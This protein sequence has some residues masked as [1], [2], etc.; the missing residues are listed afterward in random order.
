[1]P[2]YSGRLSF[3]NTQGDVPFLDS[4]RE[5]AK[6][7]QLP[8]EVFDP[9]VRLPW[10]QGQEWTTCHSG[11]L[12]VRLL[13]VATQ[14]MGRPAE[15]PDMATTLVTSAIEAPWIQILQSGW[16]VFKLLALLSRWASPFLDGFGAD[17]T[18]HGRSAQRRAITLHSQCDAGE[19]GA[20]KQ[21]RELI[22]SLWRHLDA[23][24]W[25]GNATVQ[26]ALAE[27]A[28]AGLHEQHVNV[29]TIPGQNCYWT[30]Y[31]GDPSTEAADSSLFAAS[32]EVLEYCSNLPDCIGATV[33]G[34]PKLLD[35]LPLAELTSP[36]FLLWCSPLV[37]GGERTLPCPLARA[38][39]LLTTAYRRFSASR[40]SFLPEF[41]AEAQAEV[42]TVAQQ[43]GDV[44]MGT[45]ECGVSS[46]L[47]AGLEKAR[48]PVA[49]QAQLLQ[50]LLY[51]N[52]DLPLRDQ[53]F[54]DT[55]D[56]ILPQ[57]MLQTHASGNRAETPDYDWMK[58]V[59]QDLQQDGEGVEKSREDQ[60]RAR[61]PVDHPLQVD[62]MQ[63]AHFILE[64][65]DAILEEG[66]MER[67]L[68]W[69]QPF[70]LASN[71]AVFCRW[72]DV[73]SYSEPIP[74]DPNMGLPGRHRFPGGT[75]HYWGDMESEERFGVDPESIDLILCPFIFEHVSQP[76]VAIRTLARTLRPGGFIVWAAPMYQRYHGSPHDYYRYTPKG[77]A[78]LAK[79]AGLEV[80]RLFAPGDL[81]LVNGVLM[82][83]VLPYW[84]P[85][86]ILREEEPYEKEDAPRYPLNV[87]ALLRK[88]GSRPPLQNIFRT[89]Q[90]FRPQLREVAAKWPDFLTGILPRMST[91]F[92]LT[93]VRHK[94]S[95]RVLV[96]A[97]THLFYHPNARHIRL[98]QIMCLLHQVQE[99]REQH[100]DAKGQ[101]P[102][103]IFAG[104]LNCLPETGAVQL[105]LKGE[106]TSDHEDW[107]T[108]SQF[109][110][111]DEEVSAD[112]GEADECA[113]KS[114]V[115]SMEAD[116]ADVV[117]PLPKEHW[118]NGRGIAL[119]NPLGALV[120]VY[121]KTPQKFT[122]YVHEFR[123]I[124]DYILTDDQLQSTK[125]LLA[126]AEKDVEEHGGLPSV[127][128]PSDHLSIAADLTFRTG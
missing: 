7:L 68:E 72:M 71:F 83:M 80:K 13:F 70:L 65:R 117:E 36:S 10:R 52:G 125:C 54:F 12:V 2:R 92:Q 100:R 99:L 43:V 40:E 17:L 31:A 60:I 128:H 4:V 34:D 26:S 78:A 39:G 19:V 24:V 27:E 16:P 11:L 44:V 9:E 101:L 69:D 118:Q 50:L 30:Q 47:I 110:W 87:F 66:R 79:H 98:L 64:V 120:D 3:V 121:A 22:G 122:N 59:V 29:A 93:V 109:A 89:S 42:L 96:L 67:C 124:L 20:T 94:A 104:D 58:L 62:R 5:Q 76:W 6:E 77:V 73:Y 23:D 38:A 57:Q 113:P 14:Q 1:M 108:S 112:A 123:G 119:H 126:P 15:V 18:T 41:V 95:G 32:S 107:E 8:G 49:G 74:G 81:S 82:G 115:P 85:E 84:T 106:V 103:V 55:E 25:R 97:N 90:A 111:R 51:A 114:S 33:G 45:E 86:Q 21:A 46:N 105:L 102:N 28:L 88:P 75:M 91:V 127:L 56:H 53:I 63:L 37:S 48:M 116:E 35:E 61:M